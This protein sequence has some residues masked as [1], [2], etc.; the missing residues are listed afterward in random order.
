[1]DYDYEKVNKAGIWRV[2]SG[3]NAGA[4]QLKTLSDTEECLVGADEQPT[5]TPLT[6]S[7]SSCCNVDKHYF[8]MTKLSE[9]LVSPGLHAILMSGFI[10]S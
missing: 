3:W 8:P 2:K 6:N 10:L 9:F 5:C 7:Q 1:M 4:H